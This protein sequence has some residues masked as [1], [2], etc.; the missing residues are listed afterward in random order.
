MSVLKEVGAFDESLITEDI[1]LSMRILASGYKTKLAHDAIVYTEGP[2][3]WTGLFNQRLRWRYGR[4]LTFWKQRHMFFSMKTGSNFYL[5]WIALPLSLYA[6]TLMLLDWA[7]IPFSLFYI[8]FLNAWYF[9]CLIVAMI[10][11]TTLQVLLDTKRCFHANLIL[12]S[13]F[14][15]IMAL[16]VEIVEFQALY[17]S[18]FRIV[19]GEGLK[20]Q[21]WSRVGIPD[22][23][24]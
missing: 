22:S 14:T 6:D 8:F 9:C 12:V 4:I 3:D 24:A 21:T 13:P 17:R 5:T 19:R 23:Q 16:T 1:D 7:I 10:F 18:I 11:L 15:W 2:C 20:W